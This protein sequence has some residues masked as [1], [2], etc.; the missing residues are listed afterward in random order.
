MWVVHLSMAFFDL[1]SFLVCPSYEQIDRC[2]KDDLY[3]IAQ[4]FSLAV[5]KQLLKKELKALVVDELVKRGLLVLAAPAELTVS[6]VLA[7]ALSSQKHEAEP[8]VAKG[9]GGDG[10]QFEAL[11]TSPRYNPP[12][13]GS[14]DSRERN[15]LK[16]RLQL[17]A[18]D[19]EQSRQ[20]QFQLEVRK[21]EIEADKEVRMRQLELDSQ[22][23]APCAFD[24]AGRS[25]PPPSHP[26][27]FD[28]S[29]NISLVPL[30]RETEVD[31]YFGAFERIAAALR[32][33]AEAW[34]L[35]VQCK[36]L[37]KRL[38]LFH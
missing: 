27:A 4:H 11:S 17:E 3:E 25:L 12:S 13:P 7:K 2:R 34:A 19:K 21:L 20:T 33:P 1:E 24:H 30:F 29:T 18:T 22:L 36:L 26:H 31:A 28:V 38:L 14:S 9:E 15:K 6:N 35:L 5:N 32:W 23:L 10:E 37:R 8:S 16:V